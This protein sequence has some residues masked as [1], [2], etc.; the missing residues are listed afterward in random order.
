MRIASWNVNS[1][2]V[3]LPQ[4][5]AWLDAARPDVLALQEPVVARYDTT[6]P[7]RIGMSSHLSTL[8]RQGK[9]Q[10]PRLPMPPVRVEQPVL[11]R[12]PLHDLKVFEFAFLE[13]VRA[14]TNV[15]RVR[16]YW[17]GRSAT[18]FNIH[19]HTV[20]PRKPWSD[21]AFSLFSLESWITYAAQYREATLRRA[22][23]ARRVRALVEEVDGPVL[24]T[25]DFNSTP[26][27]WAYHHIAEGLQNTITAGGRQFG[28]TYPSS[29]PLVRIDHILASPEWEVVSAHVSTEYAY[30]DHRPVV[31]R[32]RWRA[33]G[34]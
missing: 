32:L 24:V 14:P 1:L 21:S 17:E 25:G 3:R 15:T 7:D 11:A 29:F 22:K 23:E 31:A 27:N 13:G 33:D 28:G 9:Y 4:V 2:K 12:L 20:G 10:F 34:S 5:L 18:V 26:H 30:S 19:L 8:V 6:N 16:F